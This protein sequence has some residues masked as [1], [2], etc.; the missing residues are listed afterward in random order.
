MFFND[1]TL[2]NVLVNLVLQVCIL[3]PFKAQWHQ[4]V[5]FQS[6]QCHPVLAYIFNF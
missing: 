1:V 4:M 6:V 3:K 5:T 2:Y